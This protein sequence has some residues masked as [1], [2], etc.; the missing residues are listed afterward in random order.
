MRSIQH[1]Q[2]IKT[3]DPW[4]QHAYKVLAHFNYKYP[5][6]IDMEEICW[7][8]GIHIMPLEKEL[9]D[10]EIIENMKAFSIARKNGKRGVI[11]LRN[12]LDP[13]E[14][15]V[16]IAEEFCHIYGDCSNQIIVDYLQLGRS[17]KQAKRM[18]AYLLMPF[19]FLIKV[20]QENFHNQ[21]A[22]VSEVA[23]HFLVTE[24]LAHYRLECLFQHRVDLVTHIYGKLGSIEWF[25]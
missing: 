17:E 15:K 12:G 24:E 5:D 20:L 4:E 2:S 19:Y 1:L 14:R 11:Y 6:E 3:T 7:K 22:L 16:I 23:D 10:G 9:F 25:D 8:Y 18:A 21:S 13:V